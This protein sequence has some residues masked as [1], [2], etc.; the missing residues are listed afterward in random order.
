MIKSVRDRRAVEAIGRNIL[1]LQGGLFGNV[2]SVGDG[3]SELKVDVGAGYRVYFVTRGRT[4][5]VLLLGGDKGSQPRDI[6][7]AKEMAADI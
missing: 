6:V 5:I 3:V 2:Q 1:K 4:V 7:K